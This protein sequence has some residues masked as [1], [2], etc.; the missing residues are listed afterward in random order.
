MA[1]SGFPLGT[2]K[3]LGGLSRHNEKAW[4]DAHRDDYEAQ[5]LAPAR[6]FVDALAP[7]LEKIDPA[8]QAI[9]KPNG[10][11]LRIHRDTRF[12]RDKAPYKDH[13]DLWFWHGPK[14]GWDRPG[15]FFRLTPTKLMLGAGMHG[16]TPPVLAAYRKAVLDD[17]RGPAL[18]KVVKALRAAGYEVGRETYKRPPSG[19]DPAHPRVLL[20][21]HG[22]LYASWEGRHPKELGT[23]AFVGFV[24][25][26]FTKVAPLFRWEIG[27]R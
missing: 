12:A 14:K 26:H 10:S 3:F 13:L 18:A 16:F 23:P 4:F 11:I 7:R 6:D 9:S 24:A 27:L 20:L 17:K 19:V 2:V 5:Y 21:K 25:R 15:F 8:L 22:G 1:F